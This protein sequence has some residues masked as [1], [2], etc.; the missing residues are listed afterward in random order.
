M[1]TYC[2]SIGLKLCIIPNAKGHS[3]LTKVEIGDYFKHGPFE[4]ESPYFPKDGEDFT[5]EH[6]V[7][8][9]GL[10]EF[11]VQYIGGDGH[12]YWHQAYMHPREVVGFLHF[13]QRR[14]FHCVHAATEHFER[15]NRGERFYKRTLK[16]FCA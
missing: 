16:E 8:G 13:L 2:Q 7:L 3:A 5:F 11:D 1:R 12:P 4:I 9:F 15:F 10:F 6:G 14:N